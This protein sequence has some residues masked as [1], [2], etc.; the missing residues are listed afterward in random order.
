[1]KFEVTGFRELEKALMELSRLRAKAIGRKAAIKVLEPVAQTARE[2]AP[3][4]RGGLSESVVVS[5]RLDRKESRK[6][7]RAGE[8]GS[9]RVTVNVGP[10][11]PHGLLLE[12]GTGPR[13]HK[14][15]KFTGAVAP[16]PFMRPAWDA[17][18]PGMVERL[19]AELRV[20]FD[21][22]LARLERQAARAA[23]RK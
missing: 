16:H 5:T 15:G 22:V 19:A 20:E 6:A 17:H 23:K 11:K 8:T 12:F 9:H 13:H 4:L 3:R 1:M 18:T 10:A 7:W 21:K 14:N 2:L